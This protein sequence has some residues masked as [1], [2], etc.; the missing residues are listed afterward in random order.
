MEGT[1]STGKPDEPTFGGRQPKT[2]RPEITPEERAALEMP[3]PIQPKSAA[4]NVSVPIE[5]D[6][7]QDKRRDTDEV[8]I[9][10]CIRQETHAQ[11][12]QVLFDDKGG[13][14]LSD[15]ID[16]LLDEWLSRR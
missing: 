10:V 6:Q 9:S 12:S 8:W 3:I 16:H 2:I 7:C 1:K 5:H 14:S 15:L 13:R 11:V 4:R